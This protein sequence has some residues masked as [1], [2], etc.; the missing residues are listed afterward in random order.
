MTRRS[1]R[2]ACAGLLACLALGLP[3]SASAAPPH[4]GKGDSLAPH[5]L[6]IHGGSFLFEDP[7]FEPLTRVRA[8]R[9][10]FVPHYLAY[11][12][13]DLSGALAAARA[14]ARELNRLHPGRVYAY[15]TSAG[16][17]L[18]AILAGD[19]MVEAAAAKAPISDLVGWDWPLGAY[20]PD[21]YEQIGA[22]PSDRLRLSPLR[23]P[24]RRPLLI[25]HGRRDRVVPPG[26]SRQY[27]VKFKRVHLWVVQGGHHTERTRPELLSRTFQWLAARSAGARHH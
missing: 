25:V 1:V 18:A 20:G 22:G 3:A 9:A 16:G 7:L 24:A 26:M 17:T 6:L 19:G 12:L 4:I 11:P 13:Y 10:G 15:G 27:A 23:R 14:E 21:Y 5:L 8:V 2:A